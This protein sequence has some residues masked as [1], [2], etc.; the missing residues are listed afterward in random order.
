MLEHGLQGFQGGGGGDPP[1]G[2]AF[3]DQA[4]P[5]PQQRIV[6]RHASSTTYA[7]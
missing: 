7:N 3:V 2:W 5:G 4:Q 1:N 6:G